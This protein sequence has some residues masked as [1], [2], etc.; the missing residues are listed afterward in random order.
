MCA[1]AS[2]LCAAAVA[3]CWLVHRRK[4]C[5]K[6]ERI[7]M[8]C[9]PSLSLVDG[10]DALD[11]EGVAALL[12]Q[13]YWASERP[14][15]VVRKSMKTSFCFGV[16]EGKKVIAFARVV[17]DGAT[18]AWLCDVVVDKPYRGRGIG[19]E[20]LDHV[21]AHPDLQ[22]LRRSPTLLKRLKLKVDSVHEGRTLPLRAPRLPRPH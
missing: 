12:Q 8:K 6:H 2:L 4:G 19:K 7:A 16:V 5:Q 3:V 22:G 18:F 13:T 17:S 11:A 20:L 10:G 9:S 14:L 21:F 15:S 1:R